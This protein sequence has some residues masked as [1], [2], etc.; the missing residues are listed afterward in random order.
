MKDGFLDTPSDLIE[1]KEFSSLRRDM[2]TFENIKV[3]NA[4]NFSV[5]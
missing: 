5:F 1:E 2:N 3:K 4:R